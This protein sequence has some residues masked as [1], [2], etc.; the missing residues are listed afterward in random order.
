ML[1]ISTGTS[2]QNVYKCGNVYSATPCPGG[3]AIDT[4]DIR[5][6]AQKAQSESAT[7]KTAK[8]GDAME[9]SRLMQEK[10]DAKTRLDSLG[11]GATVISAQNPAQDASSLPAKS[12]VKKKKN[13]PEV[14]TAQAPGEKKQKVK[15]TKKVADKA[16]GATKTKKA[17][18]AKK[19]TASNS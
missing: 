11:A 2:A 6:G 17:A 7:S 15:K 4:Q 13:S 14:F 10:S 1:S 12:D 8:V 5:S 9:K 19:D 18:S 16:T 3:V